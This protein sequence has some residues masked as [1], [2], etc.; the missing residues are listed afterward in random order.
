LN[1]KPEYCKKYEELVSFSN[2]TIV[3]SY[4]AWVAYF[5]GA[6]TYPHIRK[7]LQAITGRE[8][9]KEKML[10]IGERNINLLKMLSSREN[11][12][13]EK[14]YLPKRFTKPLPKGA[15]ANKTVP[16]KEL[17]K[18]I[19]KYY[20]LRGW[21]KTGPTEEKLKELEMADLT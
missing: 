15:N 13:R 10:K 14:D 20:K 1:P 7:I 3:C 19:D 21:S 16:E 11:I 9:D 5:S 2:S 12:G 6:Y 17:Q 8:I 18:T 4:T